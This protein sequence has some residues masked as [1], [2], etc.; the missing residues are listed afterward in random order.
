MGNRESR[1]RW[2]GL[3]AG[4][5]AMVGVALADQFP[6]IVP[7]HQ[8][9]ANQVP[10]VRHPDTTC[11]FYSDTLTGPSVYCFGARQVIWR[12]QAN[13]GTCSL[14]VM[15]VSQNDTNWTDANA[16]DPAKFMLWQSEFIVGD[17]LNQ[18]GVISTLRNIYD[19]GASQTVTA[20][21]PYRFSR[22]YMRRRKGFSTETSPA[23]TVKC[24]A[25]CDSL[26]WSA[27]VQ[28]T[29]P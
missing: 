12:I 14:L 25:R 19:N 4:C 2:I 28:F 10:F 9:E 20:G 23:P 27:W 29:A 13:S 24:A 17:S 16:A 6:N 15:Q 7:H 11:A 8:R 1:R 22:V 3:A 5:C 21:I 26:R 18:G